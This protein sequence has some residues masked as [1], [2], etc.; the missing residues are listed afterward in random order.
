MATELL[1][2]S[3]VIILVAARLL[4]EFFQRLK[5]PPLVGELAAG[6]II[7]P[8]ILKL[9]TPNESLGVFSDLAVFFLMLL[10]GLQM[11]PREIRKAGLHAAVL[12]VI[13]FS[14][15]FASGF[16]VAYFFSP[17][18]D[19]IIVCCIAVVN[20]CCSSDYN[21]P[22]ATWN[23]GNQTG[24]YCNYSGCNKRYFFTCCSVTCS[25]AE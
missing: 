1:F 10:A 13:A 2:I 25:T 6:I 17:S 5:M 8:Y 9:I 21:C 23:I 4:G 7:G 18:H 11:D 20:N 16:A 24:Q 14:I 19:S 3:V 12:S 22:D 15:P